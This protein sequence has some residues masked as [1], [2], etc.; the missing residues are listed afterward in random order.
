MT[1]GAVGLVTGAASGIGRA[2]ALALGARGV[3]LVLADRDLA[4]LEQVVD[5]IGGD[6]AVAV[7]VDVADPSSVDRMVEVARSAHGRLDVAVN[8]AGVSSGTKESLVDL[9]D[10]LWQRVVGTNL[11][12]IFASMR[13]E[14]PLMVDGGGG[15]IVNI[16]S[17]MGLV[18]QLGS[19]A[20]IAAK[21]GVIGLTKAA[22]LEY[23]VD[24]VRVNAVAPAFIDTPLLD[25]KPQDALT[26]LAA[27]HPVKRLGTADEVAAVVGFLASSEASFVTG[28]CYAVDGG[29][30]A[31]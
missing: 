5:D 2:C 1:R 8:S 27:R 30:T 11:Y 13:A 4:G 12:G 31:Q 19:A 17:V 20:Y 21:H 6:R 25:G 15:S 24:G 26:E 28:T 10:A 14:I 22:A 29:Y 3:S 7:D 16:A 18:G 9:D 23:A